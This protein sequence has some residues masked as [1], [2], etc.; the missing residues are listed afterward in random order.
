[1]QEII[2]AILLKQI[3][4]LGEE[5]RLTNSEIYISSYIQLKDVK[6]KKRQLTLQ[7]LMNFQFLVIL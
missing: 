2:P 1:M 5:S 6:A 7:L 3:E 4:Q